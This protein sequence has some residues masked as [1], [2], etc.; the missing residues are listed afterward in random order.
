MVS[1]PHRNA[2][3]AFRLPKP[4]L[5]MSTTSWQRFGALARWLELG[6]VTETSAIIQ[7]RRIDTGILVL[8]GG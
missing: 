7:V 3:C 6:L 8:R 1:E 2:S 5:N 4:V